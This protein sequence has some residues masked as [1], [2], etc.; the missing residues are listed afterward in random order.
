MGDQ[1]HHPVFACLEDTNVCLESWLC[2]PCQ[3]SMQ[4]N[5]LI[6]GKP[7]LNPFICFSITVA[8]YFGAACYAGWWTL[9]I[10]RILVNRYKLAEEQMHTCLYACCCPGCA[11]AQQHREMTDRGENPGGL[12]FVKA[13]GGAGQTPLMK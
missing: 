5:T 8:T 1:W 4:Y 7:E 10:R 12:V 11:I 13:P 2:F 3:I 6:W 9:W